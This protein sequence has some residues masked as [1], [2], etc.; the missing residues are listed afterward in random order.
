M[1]QIKSTHHGL[2]IKH[3]KQD[4]QGVATLTSNRKLE[5]DRKKKVTINNQFKSV[6]SELSSLSREQL[7][8]QAMNDVPPK[9]PQMDPFEI[10]EE[11]IR[12]LLSGLKP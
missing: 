1:K 8:K 12:K 4:T 2:S 6:F 5:K 9:V 10:T 11:D 3:E 7:S